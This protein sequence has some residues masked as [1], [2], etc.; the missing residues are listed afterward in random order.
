[1]DP[2]ALVGVVQ[3]GGGLPVAV[4]LQELDELLGRQLGLS[5]LDGG[6]EGDRHFQVFRDV[7]LAQF[8]HHAE[9]FHVHKFDN[10]FGVF[11]KTA[12]FAINLKLKLKFKFN[13]KIRIIIE[14]TTLKPCQDRI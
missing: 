10:F 5:A 6:D 12:T 11:H 8:V 14:I 9:A 3:Q 13:A 7:F 2:S 1:M 4:V